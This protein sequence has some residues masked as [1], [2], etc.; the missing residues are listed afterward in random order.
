[1]NRQARHIAG[2]VLACL[3]ALPGCRREELPHAG[4]DPICF[5][6]GTSLA[7]VDMPDTKTGTQVSA[8]RPGDVVMVYGR[9]N[10]NEPV[11]DGVP[12][13]RQAAAWSYSNPQFWK[14]EM[15]EDYYDFLAV[16]SPATVTYDNTSNPLTLSVPYDLADQYDLMLGGMRR[17]SGSDRIA[18]VS[19]ALNH[20]LSAVRLTVTNASDSK[21]IRLLGYHFENIITQGNA[22]VTASYDAQGRAACAWTSVIRQASPSGGQNLPYDLGSEDTNRSYDYIEADL[23]IPQ[24]HDGKIGADGYAT[25][26]VD[27]IPD[28]GSSVERHARIELR[29]ICTD[30]TNPTAIAS[31]EAG[32]QYHYEIVISWD[33]GVQVQLTTTPWDRVETET[34]G[35]LIP[36]IL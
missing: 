5:S 33:G 7:S 9:R 34:P 26:V 21:S 18:P 23:M 1:M 19:L 28:D 31:W 2:I 13:T 25:L 20:V 4:T 10:T 27:Y 35:L 11:F 12:V 16:Y 32:L 36:P 30:T 29:N 14:W 6:V 22:T 8:F 15:A 24:S 3:L 17:T